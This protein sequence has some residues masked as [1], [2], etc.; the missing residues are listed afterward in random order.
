VDVIGFVVRMMDSFSKDLKRLYAEDDRLREEC[1]QTLYRVRR[2]LEDKKVEVGSS[3]EEPPTEHTPTRTMSA[4]DSKPWND[5]LKREINQTINRAVNRAVTRAIR[6]LVIRKDG[7]VIIQEQWLTKKDQNNPG[8]WN[9]ESIAA[10]IKPS[11][12]ASVAASTNEK[13]SDGD[14]Q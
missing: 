13:P 9:P 4:E 6:K 12:E 1:E 7:R 14:K 8:A 10:S 5:W 11:S 2:C 3:R